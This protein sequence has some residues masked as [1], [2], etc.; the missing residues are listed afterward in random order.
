MFE[1]LFE[2]LYYAVNEI[3]LLSILASFVWG[4]LS[5]LLSP[6][7]L[8]SIALIV[9]YISAKEITSIKKTF[10]VSSIF[11]I[12]S[13]FTIAIIGIITTLLGRLMGDIGPYGNYLG[14]IIFIIVG[15]YLM[16]IKN[17]TGQVLEFPKHM[18]IIVDPFAFRFLLGICPWSLHVCL[19]G[20]SAWC[21]FS[22]LAN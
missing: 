15:L 11:S 13:L 19:Y 8:S 6:C 16:D 17:L 21:C 18:N 20:S 5:I 3:S 4:I 7:H 22:N 14:A 9:S 2:N 1:N 10:I 12:D